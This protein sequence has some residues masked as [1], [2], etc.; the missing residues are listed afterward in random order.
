MGCTGS[1]AVIKPSCRRLHVKNAYRPVFNASSFSSPSSSS[2]PQHEFLSD[3]ERA[4]VRGTWTRLS[5]DPITNGVRVFL[6]IFELA[7]SI[8]KAFQTSLEGKSVAARPLSELVH[9]Q[10]FRHHAT[11]FMRAVDAVM[12]NLDALDVIVIPN[13]IRLGRFH[14]LSVVHFDPF[15]LDV[16]VEAMLDVWASVL[17]RDCFTI[18]A[19]NAWVKI[20]RLI[21]ISVLEGYKQYSAEAARAFGDHISS[22]FSR[23]Q[24][25]NKAYS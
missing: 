25:A 10:L 2:P 16:F 3:I 5:R 12:C 9:D 21:A 4:L 23:H 19:C 1:S 8:G 15:Y 18:D 13:L 6:R 17:G 7:P 11:R 22:K 14:A 20:F 24:T